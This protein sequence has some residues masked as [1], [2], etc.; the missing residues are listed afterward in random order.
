MKHTNL[1]NK[2][3]YL[4]NKKLLDEKRTIQKWISS[5]TKSRFK[6]SIYS[7]FDRILKNLRVREI[8]A[9][10]LIIIQ[11]AQL[12]AIISNENNWILAKK[13]P[14]TFLVIFKIPLVYSYFDLDNS[15]LRMFL[16]L[17]V[18][19]FLIWIFVGAARVL[20][21]GEKEHSKF[22]EF[23]QIYGMSLYFFDTVLVNYFF[24]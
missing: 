7:S 9:K 22:D 15:N 17:V 13:L 18:L 23:K 14:K 2:K 3:R 1:A 11:I 12:T 8:F 20:G 21:M 4:K 5:T 10:C 16:T 6:R 24:F 19:F